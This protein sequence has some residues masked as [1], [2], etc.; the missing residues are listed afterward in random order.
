MGPSRARTRSSPTGSASSRMTKILSV[1]WH[2]IMPTSP[3]PHVDS[4]DVSASEFKEQI[5]FLLKN[6]TPISIWEFLELVDGHR[7]LRSYAKPPVLLG[8]DDGLRSV[9]VN[10]LPLLSALGVPAVFF[11]IGE[12]FRNRNFLPWFVEMKHIV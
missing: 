12:I 11:V 3:P 7:S 8:F 4:S 2:G 1:F 6:Y 9:I 10:G 5:E